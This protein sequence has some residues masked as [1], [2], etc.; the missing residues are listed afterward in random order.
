MNRE[1]RKSDQAREWDTDRARGKEGE[2]N[3][4]LGREGERRKE[5][6]QLRGERERKGNIPVVVERGTGGTLLGER[7]GKG[8]G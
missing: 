1:G 8:E 3:E 7:D 5:K 2:G 6:K 4:G